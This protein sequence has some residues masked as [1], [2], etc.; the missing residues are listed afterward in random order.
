MLFVTL[1]ALI[2]LG[3]T[4]PHARTCDTYR[5]PFGAANIVPRGIQRVGRITGGRA[6]PA[7]EGSEAGRLERPLHASDAAGASAFQQ[8]LACR[9][10]AQPLRPLAMASYARMHRRDAGW[11][12]LSS[13][14]DW[15]ARPCDR[16][17]FPPTVLRSDLAVCRRRCRTA[18][19]A[20]MRCPASPAFLSHPHDAVSYLPRRPRVCR[21]IRPRVA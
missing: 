21:G 14:W 6:Y 3:V 15:W 8:S 17:P 7:Q 18:F 4:L 20:Q 1:L 11:M 5:H 10:R 2:Y 13:K 9:A 19:R 16:I 12:R